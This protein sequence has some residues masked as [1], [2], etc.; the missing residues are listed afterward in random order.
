MKSLRPDRVSHAIHSLY[1]WALSARSQTA[2]H[3]LPL[4]A[5]LEKKAATQASVVF[6]E[7]DDFAFW[8]K[9]LRLHDG[10]PKHYF[11]PVTRTRAEDGYPHSNAATMRKG[12]FWKSWDAGSSAQVE[13]AGTTWTLSPEYADIVRE[14]VLTKSGIAHKIPLLDL[15]S[16]LFRNDEFPNAATSETLL[17]RFRNQFPQA[18]KDFQ[19]LFQYSPEP[20][21]KLFRDGAPKD[22]EY[23][24]T[25]LGELISEIVPIPSLP[26]PSA[27]FDD[28]DP[29]W[30]QVQDLLGVGTSGI[31]LTGPP[32]TGKSWYAKNIA[33]RLV[34]D[35]AKDIFRVQFH[36]SYGYED[37][38]EGYRPDEAKKSGF[39]I[40]PKKFLEACTRCAVAK[41]YVVVVI[42]EINRG[43]PARVFGELL[44][45]LESGYRGQEFY[46][47]F[48]GR[49]VAIPAKLLIIGTMNPYDRSVAQI[50]A[51]FVRRFDHIAI[52]P[53]SERVANFLKSGGKFEPADI[54]HITKWF[55]SAQK[56]LQ[57]GLGH[58]F[59]KDL[60]DLDRLKLIWQY[61]IRPTADAILEFS[62]ERRD[63]FLKSFAALIKRLEGTSEV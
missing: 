10:K 44:T 17:Q 21:G 2:V 5:L 45:Y 52:E 24:A 42:D 50:D 3:L 28:D 39:D 14:K 60:S 49:P 37:F 51:A 31:I 54:D 32:A 63:D 36:P 4:L 48:S 6:E 12:T 25:I 56:L 1:N 62:P 43:D 23:E 53:S 13:G 27:S 38:V 35:A 11:N 61:R 8:D 7:A 20:A 30:T 57:V 16:L 55:E 26:G 19:T 18:D 15:A 33:A 29:I 22:Q 46:L 47:P 9:Y 58:T 34:D 40:V 41:K 59:F